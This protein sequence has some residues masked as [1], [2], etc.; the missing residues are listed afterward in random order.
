MKFENI[1]LRTMS[2]IIS[3]KIKLPAEFSAEG[4]DLEAVNKAFCAQI[5]EYTKDYRTFKR[6]KQEV[7]AII[8]ETMD[9]ELPKM[10]EEALG[11]F[12]EIKNLAN[13][14][15]NRFLID[16]NKGGI[17]NSVTEVGLGGQFKR[18]KMDRGYIEPSMKAYGTA[19]SIDLEELR[20][21]LHNWAEWK[22]EVAKGITENI[23][24]KAAE[25]L[26][27]AVSK[28]PARQKD[29]ASGFDEAKFD[30]LLAKAKSYG[31][32]VKIVCTEM[33]AQKIP[34]DTYLQTGLQEIRD[35]GYVRKYKGADVQI[36]PNA[37]KDNV[38]E[39]W[40]IDNK[41]AYIL[42]VGK[43]AKIVKIT[44]EGQSEMDEYRDEQTK[45]TVYEVYDKAGVAV[46]T[47]PYVFAYTDDS[48]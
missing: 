47:L 26:Q 15:K 12:A 39:E 16:K 29:S 43:N 35:F 2:N 32:R 38:S 27:A 9:I 10:V 17:K 1:D 4:V 11:E 24:H 30:K 44:L 31:D 28:M 46:V 45:E 6:H 14:D 36:L 40:Q 3:G 21:G 19:T 34:S 41:T 7:F 18:Y 8:E 23:A 42:P 25:G 5:D 48:L 20:M 22:T 37:L 13:G 33:F